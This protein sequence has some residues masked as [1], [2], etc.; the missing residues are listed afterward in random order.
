[1]SARVYV[2]LSWVER[3]QL[4]RVGWIFAHPPREEGFLFSGNEVMTAAEFQLEAANGVE[5][6][7]FV[8]VKLTLNEDGDTQVDAYQVM[9]HDLTF[10]MSQEIGM[11]LM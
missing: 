5:E 11:P 10:H 1:M 4:Q 7:N 8:T 3:V 6:T 2:H 9:M